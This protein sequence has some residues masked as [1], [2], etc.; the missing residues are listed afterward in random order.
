MDN[1]TVAFADE[2]IAQARARASVGRFSFLP[3]RDAKHGKVIGLLEISNLPQSADEEQAA[4][5]AMQP[6]SGDNLIGADAPLLDF[7]YTADSSPCRLVLDRH[8]IC[9]LVTRSDLQRLPVRAVLFALFIHFE[10]VLTEVLR[11]HVRGG[12]KAFDLLSDKRASQARQRWEES[13]SAGMD[14]DP[15]EALSFAD[16]KVIARKVDVFCLSGKQI[17]ADLRTIEEELRNPLAH[18]L[19]IASDPA[20]AA[21]LV[22]AAQLLRKW[23]ELGRQKLE[24]SA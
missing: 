6:L 17:E 3:V 8:E 1:L 19:S 4:R 23:I 11:R 12:E 9:G 18:G 24:A 16:K 13:R 5:T 21:T 14:R 22:R 10:L 20:R 2:P 7:V 15:L